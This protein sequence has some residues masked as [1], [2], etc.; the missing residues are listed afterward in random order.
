MINLNDAGNVAAWIALVVS[1]VSTPLSTIINSLL[2]HRFQMKMK[3]IEIGETRTS[4]ILDDYL[5]R[6]A[7]VI[8]SSTIEH[9][10][11]YW[12]CFSK[13]L[14]VITKSEDQD[15][16][17]QIDRAIRENDLIL[18]YNLFCDFCSMDISKYYPT[19]EKQQSK[20]P[21]KYLPHIRNLARRKRFK[22][23]QA[24]SR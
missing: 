18:A 7:L 5:E 3:K 16:C 10:L 23:T 9:K 2:N 11:N 13:A 8:N 19:A 21:K 12:T 17:L 20:K 15:R 6:T 1:I 14:S 22:D 24:N 4:K